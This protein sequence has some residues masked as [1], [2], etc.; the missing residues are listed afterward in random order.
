MNH[1]MG[2]I[3]PY[4]GHNFTILQVS[5]SVTR[6]LMK[7][8]SKIWKKWSKDSKKSTLI[9]KSSQKIPKYLNYLEKVAKR[10]KNIY[11]IWKK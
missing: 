9:G 6:K 8:S 2:S 1:V 5:G 3:K 11:I 4:F 10:F 7:I